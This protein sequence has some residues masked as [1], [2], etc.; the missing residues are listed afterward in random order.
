MPKKIIVSVLVA[1]F[2]I[3]SGVAGLRSCA[4]K[5]WGDTLHGPY[6]GR[7]YTNTIP[8]KPSSTLAVPEKATIEIYEIENSNN[9]VLVT[10]GGNGQVISRVQLIP[11]QKDSKGQIQTTFIKN[12]EL[13]SVKRGRDGYKVFFSCFWGWGSK[14]GGIIYL[15]TDLSFKEMSIS[16]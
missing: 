5:F 16:W 3:A 14:E 15:N 8:D 6:L 9:P 1:I 10:R 12:L 7:D 11:E 4:Q 13:R 2:V